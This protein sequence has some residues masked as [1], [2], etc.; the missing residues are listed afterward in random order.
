MVIHANTNCC[1]YL[2]WSSWEDTTF[3]G[4]GHQRQVNAVLGNLIRMNYPGEVTR[5]DVTTSLATCW[6]NY[7]LAPDATYVTTKGVV[8][9]DFW[10][11]FLVIIFQSFISDTPDFATAWFWNCRDD[12]ACKAKTCWTT[13]GVCLRRVL[14]SSWVNPYQMNGFTH[15]MSTCR[16]SR[17]SNWACS[18]MV[19]ICIWPKNNMWW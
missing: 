10:A 11:S 8:W 14:T 9:S 18:M 16:L 15:R 17:G 12:S 1:T 4:I 3:T 13:W 2:S 7:T 5:S 19:Q 6:D